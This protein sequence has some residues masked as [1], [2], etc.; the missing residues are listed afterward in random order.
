MQGI[1]NVLLSTAHASYLDYWWQMEHKRHTHTQVAHADVEAGLT[2]AA[3]AEP[4][5]PSSCRAA[6]A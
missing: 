3:A 1:T 2:Q 4:Q 5:A 6:P